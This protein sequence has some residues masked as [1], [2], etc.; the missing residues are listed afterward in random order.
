[1]K[2]LLPF[3][4]LLILTISVFLGVA[5]HGFIVYDDEEYITS[6]PGVLGGLSREGI[7]WAFTSFH[8]ANWHPLTWMSHQL[9]VELFG[10][11]A[12]GHHAMG[13]ALH[14]TN[15]LL[16]FLLLR[17]VTGAPGASLFV[18]ALFAIHPLHIESVAWA[19]ERKDLLSTLLVFPLVFAY[20]LHAARPGV[21]RGL[22]LPVLLALALMA[23]PMPVT[24]P[25]LLLALDW[26]PLGRWQGGPPPERE[27]APWAKP[28]AARHLVAE[29]LPML[30]VSAA[31]AGV[32]YLAQ[33][34]GAVGSL[35]T[36]PPLVRLGNA[37]ISY[38][39]YLGKAVWPFPTSIFYP[40]PGPTIRAIPAIL[41]VAGICAVTWFVWRN[42]RR[43]PFA[44]AG[45]TLYV[46][47][48][49]PV[50]G[51]IQVGM[52]AR[53][54]RYTYLP[55]IGIFIAAAWGAMVVSRR[56]K[57]HRTLLPIVGLLVVALL[58]AAT[59]RGLSY[60]RNDQSLFGHAVAVDD[61]NWFAHYQL[62]L[63]AQR[64]GETVAAIRH[65]RRAVA[66]HPGFDEAHRLLGLILLREGATSEAIY[67]LAQAVSLAAGNPA[68]ERRP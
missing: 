64:G 18:A 7:V 24:L 34:S 16:L 49:L 60:W 55:L 31:S 68:A 38:V 41:A 67:H 25:L 33:S 35:S 13:L 32:T 63:V 10:T 45:W 62:G 1:M 30:A 2:R 4:L 61:G 54:D 51:L 8:A 39:T 19:S 9:D 50:I 3:L 36:F 46:V 40:H 57:A 5:E 47:S 12:G 11:D 17:T 15:V 42:R 66:L 65:L 48:L 21:A 27:G 28:V 52:Q 26:W 37:A 53:A 58:S 23:K 43:F 14:A 56:L 22:L 20:L 44:I 6:N 29:K 59:V